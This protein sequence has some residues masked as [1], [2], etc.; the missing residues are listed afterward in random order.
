MARLRHFFFYGLAFLACPAIA[1]TFIFNKPLAAFFIHA[2]KIEIAPKFTG[3]KILKVIDHD[4]YI[5]SIHEPV[6]KGCC[7]FSSKRFIQIDWEIKNE[8]IFP[9]NIHEDLPG[10]EV[11]IDWDTTK[12]VA[13]V[14][15]STAV[16]ASPI[17]D[18][19]PQKK[20][21]RLFLKKDDK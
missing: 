21:L 8:G 7:S 3:G 13:K 20:M 18:L 6:S 16:S 19:S 5:T 11:E 10:L 2:S 17:Y 9:A 4:S 14:T 15:G 1:I 12:K